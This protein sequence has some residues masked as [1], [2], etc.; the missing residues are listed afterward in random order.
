MSKEGREK[1]EERE[2]GEERRGGEDFKFEMPMENC[3]S[4][5]RQR[6]EAACTRNATTSLEVI[7]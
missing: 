6:V 5:E 2:E 4:V 7:Y 3:V 1:P